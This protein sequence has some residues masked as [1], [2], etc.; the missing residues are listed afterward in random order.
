M[1]HDWDGVWRPYA[2]WEAGDVQVGV[3]ELLDCVDAPRA[4]R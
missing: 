2:S 4:R 3:F 1:H